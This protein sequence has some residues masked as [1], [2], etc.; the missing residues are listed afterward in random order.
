MQKIWWQF[1]SKCLIVCRISVVGNYSTPPWFH[2]LTTWKVYNFGVSVV[3]VCNKECQ[4]TVYK[5]KSPDLS[6][7]RTIYVILPYNH[8]PETVSKYSI[9]HSQASMWLNGESTIVS[10]TIFG[11]VIRQQFP[12]DRVGARRTSWCMTPDGCI[13]CSIAKPKMLSA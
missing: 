6:V 4:N 13:L 10:R 1:E 7:P 12:G 5:N 8:S 3:F 11:L 2:L 9:K